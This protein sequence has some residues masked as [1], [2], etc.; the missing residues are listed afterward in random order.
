[1]KINYLIVRREDKE[2][3][4]L[5]DDICMIYSKDNSKGKTTLIRFILYSLG[6][7]IPA[8]EGLKTFENYMFEISISNNGCEHILCRKAE[9][10]LLKSKEKRINFILPIQENEL[11][12]II[13][14]IDNITI[15]N[16]LLATFY[17]D[18]EKGWTL[19]NRGKIIGNIRFSIEEFIAGISDVSIND[20]LEDKKN[21][22]LELK[23]YKYFKNVIDINNEFDD[24]DI[25]EQYD[26]MVL[27]ELLNEQKKIEN[28]MLSIKNKREM[29]KDVIIKNKSFSNFI[30]DL[31]IVINYNGDEF[32]L[33]EENL[34][35]FRRNQELLI[36]KE[37]SYK[38]EEEKIKLELQKVNKKINEK[39]S[40]F[41]I[42]SVMNELEKSVDSWNIDISQIDSVIRQLKNRRD[43]INK[44]IKDK[45][46]FN[47][48]QLYDFYM[49]IEKYAK[50][51]GILEYINNRN[52]KFVLTNNL[53][54]LSGRVL[55]QM[56][57][58][59]KLT[60]IKS[61]RDKYNIYLPIIIDSP[62]T[63]ELSEKSS[64]DMLN[65][66]KRDFSKHQIIIASIYD[67]NIFQYNYI[68]LDN[69][70]FSDTYSIN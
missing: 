32:V 24:V 17:I 14:G 10:V 57:Y 59:F 40:L 53:K 2:F 38:I 48:N 36:L 8:T 34:L 46:S 16:N 27:D 33:E 68:K 69:G 6:Y 35:D 64:N 23:K 56:C 18:Q 4:Y 41:A 3:K 15:L 70:L 52:P 49:T 66:L 50:E 22:N 44:K 62:R 60:Y 37:K 65:L 54:G 12:S 43:N 13:F 55:S 61:I 25:T 9:E 19:L 30:L 11:H 47:N 26:K 5:F 7:Q 42:E 1:M 58:I 45:L 67:N 21:I 29:I 63:N 51:L 20:L 31:D 28:E 39:N